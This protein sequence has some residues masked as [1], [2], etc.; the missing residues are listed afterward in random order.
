MVECVKTKLL[1][2]IEQIIA[3]T[4]CHLLQVNH[5]LKKPLLTMFEVCGLIG[6]ICGFPLCFDSLFQ[7]SI[8]QISI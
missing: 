3:V 6:K 8:F 1:L 2:K 5:S 4:V 7:I